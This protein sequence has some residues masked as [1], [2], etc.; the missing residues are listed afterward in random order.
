LRQLMEKG[1]PEAPLV[2][3]AERV[4]AHLK[5]AYRSIIDT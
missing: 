4:L 5:P 2:D 3:P 1:A